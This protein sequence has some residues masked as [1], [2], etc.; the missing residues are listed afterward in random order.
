MNNSKE[1]TTQAK[2]KRQTAI[3]TIQSS[4]ISINLDVNKYSQAK[5]SFTGRISHR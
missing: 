3:N 5:R 2:M 1:Y 4:P